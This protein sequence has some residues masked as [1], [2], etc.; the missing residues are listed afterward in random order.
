[1][2]WRDRR[3]DNYDCCLLF[4]A[5]SKRTEPVSDILGQKFHDGIMY[6][7]LGEGVFSVGKNFCIAAYS[8]DRSYVGVWEAADDWHCGGRM[9]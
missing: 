9:E 5:G 2:C 4:C 6:T 8:G 7:Q 1:M 3:F